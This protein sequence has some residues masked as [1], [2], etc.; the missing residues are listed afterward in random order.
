[1]SKLSN[2]WKMMK[3]S[4]TVLRVDPE[5]LVFPFL[6]MVAAILVT[7]TFIL[8][9]GLVGE[10]FSALE[11]M[12][13]NVGYLGYAVG[14]L[15]YLVLYSVTFFFNAALVGAT[16]I[17]LDGG[18]P[19]VSDGLNVAFKKLGSILEYAAISATV[20]MLLRALEERAGF[21]GR[22]VI[23]LIGLSWT[24]VTFLTVPVLV[25]R[26]VSA[27]DAV[28]ESAETFKKTWGEQVVATVGIGLATFMIF[29]LM[30]LIA[31]PLI[32]VAASIGEVAVLPLVLSLGG[33]FILL[34]LVSSALKGIYSAALYRYATTGDAGE[35]FT[36]EMMEE[37]FR[38]KKRRW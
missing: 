34:A 18:D 26:D 30:G 15:Y 9:I 3:A 5:L 23:G 25:S 36:R 19:T 20:G 37:A 11:N 32:I 13:E 6:S 17:R 12:D 33:G 8:P 21:I 10:G 22:I 29:L 16:M 31:I 14:F 38:P 1:M 4:A 28:K 2:S 7:A 27:F 35:H 24:L